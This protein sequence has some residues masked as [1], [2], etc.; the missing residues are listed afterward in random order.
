MEI[1][2]IREYGIHNVGVTLPYRLGAVDQAK[3]IPIPEGMPVRKRVSREFGIDIMD[4]DAR[5]LLPE[6][7]T[8]EETLKEIRRRNKAHLIG[9]RQIV[10]NREGRVRL[11]QARHVSAGGAYV[12]EQKRIYIFDSVPE[13][14]I[15]EVLIHE[16]GH[17]V[18]YFNLEFSK[19]MEFIKDSGYNMLEFRR[20]FIPGNRLY[21]IGSKMIKVTK[22]EWRTL[23]DRFSLKSL[24]E[25]RDVFG[26]I[27][28]E[29]RRKPR[30]PWEEN[31][32]ERFAWAYE[33]FIMRNPEFHKLAERAA[34]RGDSTW[35]ADF[36]FIKDEVF[37]AN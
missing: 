27:V 17:A 26:E 9:V 8:I 11:E 10:K 12:P 15:P 18:N 35:L 20:F 16:V 2:P 25:N 28:L 30:Y 22:D 36:E 21:Q 6:V 5:F 19:F 7:A 31:P 1:N 23:M 4:T 33:W 13:K 37:G 3:Q 29:P 24:V 34:L 32:L 14:D